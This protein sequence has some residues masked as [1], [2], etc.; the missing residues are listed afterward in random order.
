MGHFSRWCPSYGS[1]RQAGK[2]PKTVP[3]M[4][5][6]SL[7]EAGVV[8]VLLT[9][10][11]LHCK[12]LALSAAHYM[13][14]DAKHMQTLTLLSSFGMPYWAL[15]GIRCMLD[16][17]K[18]HMCICMI[19][20]QALLRR[21]NDNMLENAGRNAQCLTLSAIT[22]LWCWRYPELYGRASG[23]QSQAWL[24]CAQQLPLQLLQKT[25]LLHEVLRDSGQQEWGA[26]QVLQKQFLRRQ[27]RFCHLP[28]AASRTIARQ[29]STLSTWNASLQPIT[30]IAP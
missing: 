16:P 30:A 12:I 28:D 22:W 17:N 27:K 15:E 7:E 26:E 11:S 19:H 10:A 14:T 3:V 23:C 21:F 25:L 24:L 29:S 9:A 2:S 18:E 5:E 1:L 13:H 4:A 6:V 8:R 20:A